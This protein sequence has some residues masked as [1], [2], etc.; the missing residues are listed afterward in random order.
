MDMCVYISGETQHEVNTDNQLHI[1]KNNTI[2]TL[3][4]CVLNSQHL[5]FCYYLII[6]I[7][8]IEIH[9]IRKNLINANKIIVI[10]K[11][12]KVGFMNLSLNHL[13]TLYY[14]YR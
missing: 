10:F 3:S 5:H 14:H 6:M 4:Y 12:F 8:V 7:K 13:N 2:L 11:F 9:F 1:D